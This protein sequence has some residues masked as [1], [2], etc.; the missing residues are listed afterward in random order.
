VTDGVRVWRLRKDHAWI[1]ARLRECPDSEG[2]E[3][4]FFY[5]GALLWARRWTSREL[6]LT[7]ADRQLHDLQRAGWNTHW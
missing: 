4:Q 6:A 3:I 2:V 7:H 1:D 5:D